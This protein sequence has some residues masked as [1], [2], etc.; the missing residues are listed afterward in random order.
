ML[1]VSFAPLDNPD[2]T[3]V[4]FSTRQNVENTNVPGK[5]LTFK[6]KYLF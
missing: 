5:S 3:S 6:H 4:L 1:F 2:V